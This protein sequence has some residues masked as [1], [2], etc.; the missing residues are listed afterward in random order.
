M[1][2]CVYCLIYELC[3]NKRRP[4]AVLAMISHRSGDRRCDP[5]AL[6]ERMR[7][8]DSQNQQVSRCLR[9]HHSQLVPSQQKRCQPWERAPEFPLLLGLLALSHVWPFPTPHPAQQVEQRQIFRAY[10]SQKRRL[11]N[12]MRWK[13]SGIST[14]LNLQ[15]I[16]NDGGHIYRDFKCLFVIGRVL[17]NQDTKTHQVTSLQTLI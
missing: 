15:D 14:L 3:N 11:G 8:Q 17:Q 2:R 16:R 10:N 12:Y 6:I 7:S 13:C 4:L 1:Y 5:K 9:V